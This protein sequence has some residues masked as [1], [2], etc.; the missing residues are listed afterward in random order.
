MAVRGIAGFLLI[1]P[2]VTP[3]GTPELYAFQNYF[4]DPISDGIST[5]DYKA[6]SLSPIL[7]D[8]SSTSHDFTVTFPATVENVDLV[9][10]CITNRY[11]VAAFLQ[12]WSAVEGLEA[13]TSFNPFA[14][15][16]GESFTAAADITTIT[17]TVR[18][19]AEAIEGD[20]PWRKIPWTILGPLSLSS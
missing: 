11:T 20:I 16:V 14:G 4:P 1:Y 2:E 13:P 9:D 6:F 18:P 19:Y 10:A 8:K 15:A 12:R 5:Y 3:P 17:L 7:D